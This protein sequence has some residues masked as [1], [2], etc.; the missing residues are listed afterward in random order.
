MMVNMV[1]FFVGGGFEC[2]WEINKVFEEENVKVFDFV[3]C[4]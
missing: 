3:M 4:F 1:C 2:V